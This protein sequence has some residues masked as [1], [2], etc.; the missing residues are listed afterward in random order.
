MW[1][2]TA[3]FFG[4]GVLP[5]RSHLFVGDRRSCF[6]PVSRDL[7]KITSHL[8]FRELSRVNFQTLF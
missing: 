4:G 3:L 1:E 8:S 2:H 7:R 5:Q 6:L